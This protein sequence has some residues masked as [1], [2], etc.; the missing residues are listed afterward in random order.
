MQAAKHVKIIAI[1][2]QHNGWF[3]TNA[4]LGR[5]SVEWASSSKS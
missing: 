1:F 3:R 5:D 4:P 2:K